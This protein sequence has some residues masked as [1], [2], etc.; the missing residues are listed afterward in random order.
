MRFALALLL[1]APTQD[2]LDPG[3]VA[4]YYAFDGEVTDFPDVSALKPKIRRSE[5]TIDY[6]STGDDFNGTGLA[7][8]FAVRW[9][10]ILRVPADGTVAFWVESDDG[11]RLFI[12]GR[13]VVDNGGLHGMAAKRGEIELTKGDHEIRVE[14]FENGGDAGCKLSWQRK[15]AA[16]EIVPASAL[17]HRKDA[18]L[19]PAPAPKPWE[20][21]RRE[22]PAVLFLTHSAGFR[23]SVV[24]RK[25][26]Q[27]AHAERHLHA[28]CG[29]FRVDATQ[30]CGA[31]TAENLAKYAAVVFY[32]TGEL[33]ITEANRKALLDYVKN[34]G[35]FVGIHPATDTFYKWAD[36]GEMIGG[37]FDGHPWHQKVRVRVEAKDHPS[38]A[39]LGDAFEIVDE[40]YQFRSWDRSKLK[41]LLSLD[42]ESVKLSAPGV[43][44]ADKDFGIAW[45]RDYGKGRVF[46]TALGHREDVWTDSRFLQHLAGGVEWAARAPAVDD[47]G[48][49]LLPFGDGWKQAGPGGFKVDG[50]VATPHGGMGLYYVD[51]SYGNFMLKLEFQQ[52]SIESNS[53]VFVRFPRVDG[54]PW[55]PVKE[56]YEVQIAGDQAEKTSTGAIYSFQAPSSVPLKP[57]GEWNA[58][59]IVCVGQQYV[60]RLN[61]KTVNTFKGE[62]AAKGMIGLQ[63]HDDDGSGKNVVKFRNVRVMELPENAAGVHVLF[64][65]DLRS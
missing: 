37:Y 1:L 54:D 64:E 42:V 62:R 39:H 16:R 65:G 47:E 34:G 58:Y 3:L 7:D 9:S 5:A 50:G 32:T 28:A 56:G 43:N 46:Y 44:R 51:R 15:G 27:W 14:M 18:T 59:E 38:T 17:F 2:E 30:D 45:C 26:G 36:Y 55:I 63:N 6:D 31:I 61:G 57:A 11:S 53:G 20:P 22:G 41:V 8:F 13:E 23:H 33:P 21:M 40:I 12:D 29:G 49:T 60:V 52:K 35:G 10:G 24:T 48:F 4:E 19:K 25:A